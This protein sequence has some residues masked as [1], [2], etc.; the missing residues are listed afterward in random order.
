MRR[1][2]GKSH[3]YRCYIK[4]E[5]ASA[6]VWPRIR[7][8]TW[9]ITRYT[10]ARTPKRRN[11]LQINKRSFSQGCGLLRP[12][13]A[14]GSSR[15][16]LSVTP[17]WDTQLANFIQSPESTGQGTS[18]CSRHGIPTLTATPAARHAAVQSIRPAAPGELHISKPEGFRGWK[19][20]RRMLLWVTTPCRMVHGY[21]CSVYTFT[22]QI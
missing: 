10:T 21:Q 20:L 6:S 12:A 3:T 22:R 14:D 16:Q 13:S 17:L 4:H 2:N 15:L 18:V 9:L 1:K 5:D 8:L 11:V 7:L 19:D